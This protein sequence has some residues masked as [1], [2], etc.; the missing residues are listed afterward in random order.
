MVGVSSIRIKMSRKG[1]STKIFP[2]NRSLP[3]YSVR[4]GRVPESIIVMFV[5]IQ[6]IRH[7]QTATTPASVLLSKKKRSCDKAKRVAENPISTIGIQ[8][9]KRILTAE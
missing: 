3:K 5:I 4:I 6:I 2:N 1:N 7:V 8:S 9:K